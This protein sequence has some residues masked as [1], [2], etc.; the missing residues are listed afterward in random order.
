MTCHTTPPPMSLARASIFTSEGGGGGQR[1]GGVNVSPGVPFQ[2]LPRV[3]SHSPLRIDTCHPKPST[4][5]FYALSIDCTRKI[6]LRAHP[7][8]VWSH[9]MPGIGCF[10]AKSPRK[11]GGGGH[12]SHFSL[13]K[14]GGGAASRGA[15][16]LCSA[17]GGQQ[18][19]GASDMAGGPSAVAERQTHGVRSKSTAPKSYELYPG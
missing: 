4:I 13:L 10:W 12:D 1:P 11:R 14:G 19:G 6:I 3:Y 9:K 18:Q 5:H 15:M 17:R 8:T 2:G 16:F 7:L